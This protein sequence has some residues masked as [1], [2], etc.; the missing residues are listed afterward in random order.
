MATHATCATC[1]HPTKSVSHVLRECLFAVDVWNRVG[2]FNTV[3]NDC[4]DEVGVWIRKGIHAE[5]GLLFGIV[6]WHLWKTRN[7][8]IFAA[9]NLTTASV[10]FRSI[11]R[12]RVVLDASETSTRTLE[13]NPARRNVD[14]AWDP[15]PDHWFTI[16]SD[17]AVDTT[18][19]KAAAG[20]LMRDA[21]GRCLLAYAMNLGICSNTRAEIRE[22]LRV[23]NGPGRLGIG[24]FYSLTQKRLFQ[25]SPKK[26]RWQGNLLWK[27][28]SS[29]NFETGTGAC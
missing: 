9:S 27:F 4:R 14:V 21:L 10:A 5:R 20:G 12:T 22:Q 18:T 2:G 11:N 24:T 16:N 6:C 29:E 25:F 17:G 13:E 15:G 7:E 23:S 19:G 8:R 26:L 28:L 3:T 1:H